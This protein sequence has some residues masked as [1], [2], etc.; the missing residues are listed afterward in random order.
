MHHYPSKGKPRPAAKAIADMLFPD[1]APTF[2]FAAVTGTNGK[3]TT[4]RMLS[5]ILTMSGLNVGMTCT[6]GIYIGGERLKSG[7]CSGPESAR[8]INGSL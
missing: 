3:T 4:V 1:G 7:D 8:T 2:P 6:D 5:H